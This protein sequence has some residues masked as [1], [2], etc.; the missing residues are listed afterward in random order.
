MSVVAITSAAGVGFACGPALR[1]AIVANLRPR[2]DP[3]RGRCPRCS[4]PCLV[5]RRPL[6]VIPTALWG[7]CPACRARLAPPAVLAELAG[8]GL[9]GMLAVRVHRALVLAAACTLAAAG[10][11]TELRRETTFVGMPDFD[12]SGPRATI[13]ST[14]RS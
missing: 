7:R 8:A 13:K 4:A 10:P 9:L 5:L 14:D 12:P 3:A 2:R 1:A 6:A 11:L